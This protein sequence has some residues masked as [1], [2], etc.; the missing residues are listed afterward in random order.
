[1]KLSLAIGG[2][3]SV[4]AFTWIRKFLAPHS[5]NVTKVEAEADQ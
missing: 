5:P 1:M 3:T 2:L 4:V